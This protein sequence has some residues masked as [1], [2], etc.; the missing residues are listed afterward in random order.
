[1]LAGLLRVVPE[2][3]V[4]CSRS[5]GN[6]SQQQQRHARF[7]RRDVATGRRTTA[8]QRK[9]TCSL[10]EEGNVHSGEE[11]TAFLLPSALRCIVA[12]DRALRVCVALACRVGRFRAG[13]GP[14]SNG[15][16]HV[17]MHGTTE[18]RTKARTQQTD[19]SSLF[20][21]AHQAVTRPQAPLPSTAH[22]PNSAARC[23]GA[24]CLPPSRAGFGWPRRSGTTS[25]R[26]A[27]SGSFALSH[28]TR[29]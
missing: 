8:G 27:P 1:M 2:V 14:R 28:T 16:T 10:R 5:E 23:W 4:D 21:C 24:R 13:L 6:A 26:A 19:A 11:H 15:A 18:Q 3:T 9:H 17:C 20:A 22:V 12:R 25:D 7:R 29:E